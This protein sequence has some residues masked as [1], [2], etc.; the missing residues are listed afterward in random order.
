MK[1]I[2]TRGASS[3]VGF[4]DVLIAGL[5]VDGGLYIPHVWPQLDQGKLQELCGKPFA[6]V[7]VYVLSLFCHDIHEKDLHTIAQK[8]YGQGFSHRCIA[9]LKQLDNQLWV[10]EFFHGPTQSGKDVSMRLFSALFDYI[11]ARYGKQKI[12]FA[13]A[14]T[15]NAGLA[16]IEAFKGKENISLFVLHP[17]NGLPADVRRCLT[18]ASDPNI[19]NVAIDGTFD[20]CQEMVKGLYNDNVLLAQTL[21]QTVNSLNWVRL[22]GSI[23]AYLY[24]AINIGAPHR[25]VGFAVP[26]GNF[27]SLFAAYALF[28][29]G[30]PVA[31]LICANN[32]ND[33]MARF[34]ETGVMQGSPYVQ[35]LSPELD[36]RMPANF[37]RLLFE[38]L[39]RKS[40]EMVR[41]LAMFRA[42]GSFDVPASAHRRYR[43]LFAGHRVG[44]AMIIDT[45]SRIYKTTGEMIDPH[46]AVALSGVAAGN[47]DRDYP[48]VAVS[49]APP[50]K[51][52][53]TVLRATGV[54]LLPA[55]AMQQAA[56]MPER[57]VS[58]R[59]EYPALSSYILD[60]LRLF[61]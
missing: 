19:F 13:L 4:R 38:L 46:T 54:R 39:D 36:V 23:I 53:D 30:L 2:S 8:A 50:T 51:Y 15:G 55:R 42:R 58:L 29:M 16:A 20:D 18:T 7:A 35:T 27:G 31:R 52:W 34:Y 48:V 60:T 37:E 41:A 9:P 26:S 33:A 61:R 25:A 57:Y 17:K 14:T 32:A 24:A 59:K 22:V 28:R 47:Y 56:A 6:D 3:A 11:F 43:T 49:P 21:I 1:Y 45:I 40:G 10:Q 5:P 44:D 12:T